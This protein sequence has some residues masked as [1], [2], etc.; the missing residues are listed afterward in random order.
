MLIATS[1]RSRTGAFGVPF[2]TGILGT[3]AHSLLLSNSC[4][5]LWGVFLLITTWKDRSVRLIACAILLVY[6]L[7]IAF[8]MFVWG[9]SFAVI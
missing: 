1:F 9:A 6:A 3:T 8:A 2:R 4:L 5:Y 7:F